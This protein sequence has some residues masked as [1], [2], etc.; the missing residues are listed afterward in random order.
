MIRLRPAVIALAFSLLLGSIA[1][2]QEGEPDPISGWGAVVDPLGDCQ[3]ELADGTLSITVPGTYHDLHF[4]MDAPRVMQEVEG[5][6]AVEVRVRRFL[7]PKPKSA[8][9]PANPVSYVSGG[10]L[11]WQ[12]EKNF[13]RF[14]RAANGDSKFVGTFGQYFADGQMIALSRIELPDED[15]HLRIERRQGRFA[16]SQSADGKTWTAVRPKGKDLS[17]PS[18]VKVGV[19]AM[20][21]T[22]RQIVHEFTD[23]KLTAN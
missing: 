18:R 11:I 22:N 17:L 8:V 15:T 6:F 14:Q 1:K 12:D 9:N 10:L 4:G 7:R 16:L 20:N 23:L 5:D 21:A 13:I 19:F 2:A 3:V